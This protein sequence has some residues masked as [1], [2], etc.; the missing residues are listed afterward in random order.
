MTNPTDS[1]TGSKH[2]E[3]Q[4]N[5]AQQKNITP[6]LNILNIRRMREISIDY[7]V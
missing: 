4:R 3:K 1:V 6:N 2:L 5:A 7:A